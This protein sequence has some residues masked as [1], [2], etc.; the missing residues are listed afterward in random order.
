MKLIR[1]TES[2]RCHHLEIPPGTV[3]GL[4]PELAD[5]F[6]GLGVGEFA[7]PQRA[8]I[9]PQEV[10]AALPVQAIPRPRGRPRKYPIEE[11]MEIDG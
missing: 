6:V 9:E 11:R 4:P 3:V 7:E 10:R 1:L 5:R 8:V 2:F